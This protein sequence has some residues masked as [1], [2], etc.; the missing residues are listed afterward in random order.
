MT[1]LLQKVVDV[2]RAKS[3]RIPFRDLKRTVRFLSTL[4]D[5]DKDIADKIINS[6]FN[7]FSYEQN[8]KLLRNYLNTIDATLLPKA[9][10]KYRE[11]QLRLLDFAKELMPKLYNIGL[12]PLLNGGA[13][14]GAVRNKGFIPW[15]DD[16]DFYLIRDEYNK[17]FEYVQ[18]KYICLNIDD[19]V[20]YDDFLDIL[21][22]KLKENKN[23]LIWV[24]KPSCLTVYR[25]S[26]L[27]DVTLVD[28]F[29][30]EYLN[31]NMTLEEYVQYR[32]DCEQ[33]V[34]KY[35]TWGE[36]LNYFK[37]ELSNEKVYVKESSMTVVGWENINFL[38]YNRLVPAKKA[39]VF[40]AKKIEFEDYYFYTLQ[41][42]ESYLK[43]FYGDYMHIP[44]RIRIASY[45]ETFILYLEKKGRKYCLSMEQILSG[46]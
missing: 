39:D 29:P 27:E 34:Q 4:M 18:E 32:K 7:Y 6:K 35:T 23:E 12:T 37:K 22:E 3:Y 11:Y 5:F 1:K 43:T 15:D 25:G 20:E 40:P 36:K 26:S 16:L 42:P 2:I 44:N 8:R 19:C 46:K 9:K 30:R 13:L 14:L 33:E 10:G 41:N 21:D 28:F 24:K 38:S 45:L 17:L 31:P